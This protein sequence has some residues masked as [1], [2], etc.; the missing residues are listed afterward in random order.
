MIF[1]F[2]CKQIVEKSLALVESAQTG[3]FVPQKSRTSLNFPAAEG[4]W[5]P[6]MCLARLAAGTIERVQGFCKPQQ[7]LL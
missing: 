1:G 5:A 6:S 4:I 3:V 7:S 2:L